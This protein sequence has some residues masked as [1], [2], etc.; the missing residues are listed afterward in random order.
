MG[1]RTC[2]H[3]DNKSGARTMET[4]NATLVF[5]DHFRLPSRARPTPASSSRLP[6]HPLYQYLHLKRI[7]IASLMF[8]LSPMDIPSL[9]KIIYY[10]S[11]IGRANSRAQKVLDFGRTLCFFVCVPQPLPV[12]ALLSGT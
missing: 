12:E 7:S 11:K 6:I 4:R 5:P 8:F 10:E 2:A 1:E 9:F 3:A